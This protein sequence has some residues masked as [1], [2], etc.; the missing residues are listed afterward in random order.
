VDAAVQ[1]QV[2]KVLARRALR[3]YL[4]SRKRLLPLLEIRTRLMAQ[5]LP[6]YERR[7]NGKDV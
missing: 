1:S 7:S 4:L 2:V 3:N 6:P 5:I